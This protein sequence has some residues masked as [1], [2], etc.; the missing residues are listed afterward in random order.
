MG[1]QTTIHIFLLNATSGKIPK[2]I[3]AK[4]EQKYGTFPLVLDP[5]EMCLT[6]KDAPFS[7]F[8]IYMD[9]HDLALM[10]VELSVDWSSIAGAITY[11]D[12]QSG[13]TNSGIIYFKGTKAEQYEFVVDSFGDT[14]PKR[15]VLTPQHPMMYPSVRVELKVLD[16]KSLKITGAS[17]ELLEL[18]RKDASKFGDFKIESVSNDSSEFVLE[19]DHR[20]GIGKYNFSRY[21]R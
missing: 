15:Y 10:I 20:Q 19:F 1:R 18:I 6:Y 7:N 21:I 9:P 11:T 8:P 4:L 2:K 16:S 17:P 5:N 13:G 14:T 3:I 12:D